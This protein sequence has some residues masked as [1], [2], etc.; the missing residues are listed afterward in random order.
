MLSKILSTRNGFRANLNCF[1]QFLVFLSN[2]THKKALPFNF[3]RSSNLR[4]SFLLLFCFVVYEL[5]RVKSYSF[6]H[7]STPQ[8]EPTVTWTKMPKMRPRGF[9]ITLIS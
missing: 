8:V 3:I 2:F 4:F 9:A 6:I 5:R 7:V 1:V